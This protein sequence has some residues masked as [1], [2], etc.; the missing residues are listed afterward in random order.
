MK[1]L[2]AEFKKINGKNILVIKANT[3]EIK[4]ENGKKDVTVKVPTIQMTNN[5][6]NKGNK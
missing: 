4:H 5:F 1:K 6:I 2:S 3:E